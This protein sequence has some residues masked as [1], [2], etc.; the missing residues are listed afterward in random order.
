MKETIRKLKWFWAWQDEQEEAWLRSMSQEGL[1]LKKPGIAGIYEFEQGS[2]V[3]YFYRL[4]Y[5]FPKKD[6]Q[7]YYQIFS[8]AGWE[9][10]GSMGGWQYFRKEAQPGEV[11]EIYTDPQSKIEKYKKLMY[12]LIILNPVYWFVLVISRENST[13][14][15]FGCLFIFYLGL[16]LLFVIAIVKLAQRI[17]EL[18]ASL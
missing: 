2:P 1:H 7:H 17:K 3:N 16:M 12:F 18:K 9:H 10:I 15:W 13:N 11:P 5:V 4:D 6:E 8:D 14:W